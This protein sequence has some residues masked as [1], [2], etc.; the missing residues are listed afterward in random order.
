MLKLSEP[1]G[2]RNLKVE[3]LYEVLKV[4]FVMYVFLKLV[5][6]LAYDQIW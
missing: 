6:S 5:N 2:F 3:G 1:F 4:S